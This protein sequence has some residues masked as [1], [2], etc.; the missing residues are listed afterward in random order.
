MGVVNG[1]KSL[2]LNHMRIESI[3]VDCDK[4]IVQA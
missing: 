4:E 2:K 3:Y 1:F